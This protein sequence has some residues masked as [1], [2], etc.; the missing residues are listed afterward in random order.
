MPRK[1]KKITT[2]KQ[3][4]EIV[5]DFGGWAVGDVAWGKTFVLGKSIYGEIKEF[6]P[7]DKSGPSVTLF[8]PAEGRF[9]TVLVST[10]SEN[11][12]KKKRQR[13][14]RRKSVK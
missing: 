4:R 8:N 7:S 9:E 2:K 12:H 11:M 6:H 13:A 10:L 5:S 3:H 1:K 14:L